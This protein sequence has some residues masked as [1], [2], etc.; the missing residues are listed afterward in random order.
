MSIV[1]FRQNK[2]QE[3]ETILWTIKNYK[4][5]EKFCNNTIYLKLPKK[6]W[7]MI[8]NDNDMFSNSREPLRKY[9]E[10][11]NQL[12][13]EK[14]IKQTVIPLWREIEKKFLTKIGK[15]LNLNPSSKYICFLTKYGGGG[16]FNSPDT[17]WVRVNNKNKNDI[18]Y[19][20][21][22]IAHEIVHI[23]LEEK[24]KGKSHEEKEKE[25]DNV[26]IKTGLFK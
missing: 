26:L 21:Y 25:V 12:I 16:S 1:L 6:L 2:K 19:F 15:I 13:L 9:L 8:I 17:I 24:Y 5:L 18:K 22:T 4:L 23:L 10:K 3:L 7:Q 20:A 11:T 14:N